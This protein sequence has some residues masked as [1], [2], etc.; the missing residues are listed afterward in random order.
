[1]F[2][3]DSRNLT[4]THWEPLIE[5]DAVRGFRVRLLETRGRAARAR[6]SAFRPIASARHVDFTGQSRGDCQI[7]GGKVQLEL[8]ANEWLELE[9]FWETGAPASNSVAQNSTGEG[10]D[11]GDTD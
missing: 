9:A 2:H 10:G 8:A 3:I 4:A 11:A 6:L 1:L 7:S 5:N